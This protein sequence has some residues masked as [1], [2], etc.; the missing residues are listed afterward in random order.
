MNPLAFFSPAWRNTLILLTLSILAYP[1]LPSPS[2]SASSPTLTPEKLSSDRTDSNKPL[3][4][5]ML[6]RI[7]PDA[8]VWKDRNDKHMVLTKEAAEGKL[9]VQDA[10]KPSVRRL[11]VPRLVV[12]LERAQREEGT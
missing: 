5:R 10:Q 3:V 11:G 2:S 8:N 12:T 1:Y 4:T 7:M 6:A 9:L